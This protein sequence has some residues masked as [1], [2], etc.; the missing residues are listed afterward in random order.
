MIFVKGFSTQAN[1]AMSEGAKI[2]SRLG[3]ITIGCEH[4]ISALYDNVSFDASRVMRSCARRFDIMEKQLAVLIGCGE[5]THLDAKDM[6]AELL[7]IT[8]YAAVYGKRARNENVGTVEL[9]AAIMYCENSTVK[10]LLAKTGLDTDALCR[11]LKEKSTRQTE[12]EQESSKRKQ[13]PLEKYS[14]DLTALAAEG[15]L[16]P[17][18]GREEELSRVIGVLSRRR[19]N[20][21]CLIGEPGVGKTAMAE[22]LA[23]KIAVGEVP[24]DMSAMRLLSLDMGALVAGTKYRGDFEERF[25]ALISEAEKAKNVILFIDEM[26]TLIGTGSA[27]GSI[28]ASNLLKPLLARGTVRVAG[29]TTEAE[30]RKFIE[31]D[32]AL[33]RRFFPILVGEPNEE[34][35]RKI[36]EGLLPKYESFHN[37]IIKKEAVE[38]SIYLAQ[39]F[40]TERRFPDKAIDLIDEAAAK[41]RTQNRDAAQH[42][43]L[44]V[45]RMDIENVVSQWAGVDAH[46]LSDF[47]SEGLLS[48][49]ERMKKRV[50]GQENAISAVA[51]AI[52]RARTGLKDV[53]KPIG[54]FL[55]C[56]PTGVGKTEVCRALAAEFFADD[57][58]LLRFDMSEYME[59]NSV[60]RLIGS[61]PGYVGYGDG[62]QLTKAVRKKP[63]SVVLFDEAEKANPDVFN[64]FL[65]IMEEGVLTDSQGTAVDFKNCIVVMTTNI[66]AQKICDDRPPLGF[67]GFGYSDGIRELVMAS[68]GNV[69]SPELQ[70]RIDEIVVFDR[71]KKEQLLE[72][73]KGQLKKMCEN[74]KNQGIEIICDD[75]VA[76]IIV[77]KSDCTKFGAR[78]LKRTLTRLVENPL[79]ELIIKGKKKNGHSFCV[80]V[81]DGE[82]IV[83]Q[84]SAPGESVPEI[85]QRVFPDYDADNE[86]Q[87]HLRNHVKRVVNN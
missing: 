42:M 77:E 66:G 31:K 11:E 55:F 51:K 61:P 83:G 30:Y 36:I 27:E 54:C 17:C 26:H 48:L 69:F 35:T 14:V 62:G 40:L 13:S 71:L 63:Y 28:D 19:K 87:N 15:R 4:V 43:I 81:S 9:L 22:A 32:K 37:V 18:I 74:A 21:P 5:Q 2:A 78:P 80:T 46:S 34:E 6:T 72:I 52:M 10:R 79:C 82:I 53:K 76:E 39:R 84:M 85:A 20:N 24:I 49:E 12:N 25:K 47:E 59:Q 41:K 44:E 73:S 29:A 23:Q 65:Q 1:K 58:A 8:S 56:G 67:G 60:A 70:N 45:C 16:D 38:A 86:G 50:L 64:L 57:R 3:H 7:G 33:E 75:K 68:V